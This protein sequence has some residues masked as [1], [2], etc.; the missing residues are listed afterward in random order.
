MGVGVGGFVYEYEYVG[1]RVKFIHSNQ[2]FV[3]VYK[4][5]FTCIYL[6][7]DI[8][9]MQLIE[10]VREREREARC[11]EGCGRNGCRQL[12]ER[13]RVRESKRENES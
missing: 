5:C 13:T 8:C 1:G 2:S 3:L 11:C 4:I 10:S 7:L 6:S 9:V 12:R